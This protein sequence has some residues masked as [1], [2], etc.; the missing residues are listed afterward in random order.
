MDASPERHEERKDDKVVRHEE[1]DPRSPPV[2]GAVERILDEEVHGRRLAE[3]L[4]H[5][6]G[7]A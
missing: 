2:A 5:L 3:E 1:V 7:R 6:L 4:A